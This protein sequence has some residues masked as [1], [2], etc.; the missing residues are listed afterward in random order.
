MTSYKTELLDTLEEEVE[1]LSPQ[2][3]DDDASLDVSNDIASNDDVCK[4]D[5][6][7]SYHATNELVSL[8]FEKH[9]R[10]IGS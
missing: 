4:K 8:E 10:G 6:M 1:C 3:I 9:T 2:H 7:P 5:D